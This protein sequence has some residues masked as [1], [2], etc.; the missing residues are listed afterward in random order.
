MTMNKWKGKLSNWI[1]LLKK[2]K[3]IGLKYCMEEHL[4]GTLK[5]WNGHS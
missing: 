1:N 5:P 2:E 3:A 4:K